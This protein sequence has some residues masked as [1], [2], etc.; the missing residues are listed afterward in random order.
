M[1]NVFELEVD[2]EIT[3]Y[4]IELFFEGYAIEDAYGDL[5]EDN[6]SCV[7]TIKET[8]TGNDNILLEFDFE[9][10]KEEIFDDKIRKTITTFYQESFSKYS[11]D[12]IQDQD[13]VDADAAYEQMRDDAL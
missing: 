1:N 2:G 11:A 6:I 12:N 8:I 4:L 10:L 7:V 13:D 9:D 5:D 3:N